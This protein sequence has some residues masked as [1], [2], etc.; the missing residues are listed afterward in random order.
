MGR[1]AYGVRG[2]RLR[3]EDEI[4]SVDVVTAGCSLFTVTEKGFGKSVAC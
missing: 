3:K 2:I 1:A 4:V